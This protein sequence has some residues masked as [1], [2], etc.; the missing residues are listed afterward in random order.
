MSEI[1]KDECKKIQIK[2]LSGNASEEIENELFNVLEQVP[3][4]S[5]SDVAV[6]ISL[7][8]TYIAYSK[9]GNDFSKGMA[10]FILRLI[11]SN[12]R[13]I[14]EM[15]FSLI[16]ALSNT[17][18]LKSIFDIIAS[19]YSSL[20]HREL[21]LLLTFS[22]DFE[23][24]ANEPW[25]T[26]IEPAKTLF[27]DPLYEKKAHRFVDYLQKIESKE[28]EEKKIHA[29]HKVPASQFTPDFVNESYE[30]VHQYI[31]MLRDIDW[32]IQLK[33]VEG[34]SNVIDTH[35]ELLANNAKTALINLMDVINCPRT[36]VKSAGLK[37]A[38][39]LI[40]QYPE[41]TA[42]HAGKYI[43][44]AFSLCDNTH[45]FIAKDANDILTSLTT[46]LPRSLV[47][48]DLSEGCHDK[49][50]VVR[51]SAARCFA[52]MADLIDKQPTSFVIGEKEYLIG[53]PLDNNEYYVFVK[54]MYE[55]IRDKEEIART[56]SRKVM[57]LLMK[58]QRFAEVSHN[59]I[60][61]SDDYDMIMEDLAKF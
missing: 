50:Q 30:T 42:I 49:N 19:Q 58:D 31:H 29:H 32:Q 53:G 57:K 13:A 44:I 41:N 12:L 4:T 61:A 34:L 18:K 38:L 46:K 35:P 40:N 5:A 14:R 15:S 9:Y 39:E 55:L 24:P 56:D 11:H 48:K 43:E 26:L 33:A 2:I 47:L 59:I 36:M 60:P 22:F 21:A 17:D 8:L 1:A 27:D 6:P 28:Q 45:D 23:A 16:A 20:S 52:L 51:A 54:S 37:L 10:Q 25:R 3:L 7:I